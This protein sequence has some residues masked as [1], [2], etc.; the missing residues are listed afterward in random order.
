MSINNGHRDIENGVLDDDPR[1]R[2][3]HP[4]NVP[5]LS[6]H[7][8]LLVPLHWFVVP[9]NAIVSNPTDPSLPPEERIRRRGR[10]RKVEKAKSSRFR[11]FHI[12]FQNQTLILFSLPI[13][14]HGPDRR[15]TS[16]TQTRAPNLI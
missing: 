1:S 2:T 11:M 5:R 16:R 7:V 9:H 4:G 13:T 6:L 14:F 12:H 15:V 8:P 10:K 3:W